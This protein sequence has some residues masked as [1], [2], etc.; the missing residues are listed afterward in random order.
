MRE[1]LPN[2]PASIPNASGQKIRTAKKQN[3]SP[4]DLR[5][6]WAIRMATDPRWS[7][8]SDSDA[9]AAMGHDLETHRKHY[10]KWISNEENRVKVMS[11]ITLPSD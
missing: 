9:A 1:E 4:Y 10:Q 2:W 5:H 8:V 3:L 7:H 6:T 11:K